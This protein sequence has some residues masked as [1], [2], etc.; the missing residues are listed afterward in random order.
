LHLG[1]FGR[2]QGAYLSGNGRRRE[3]LGTAICARQAHGYAKCQ[4]A[5]VKCVAQKRW[6]TAA[7]CLDVGTPLSLIRL[8]PG[9]PE[10]V[11]RNN[12]LRFSLPFSVKCDGRPAASAA[13]TTSLLVRCTA[14]PASG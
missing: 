8:G 4:P 13:R 11:Q 12:A 3:R 10:N 9:T 7:A 1:P 2:I 14:R 5:H 6:G